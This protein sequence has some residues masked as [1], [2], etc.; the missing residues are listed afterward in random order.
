MQ[1]YPTMGTNVFFPGDSAVPSVSQLYKREYRHWWISFTMSL[2]PPATS[3]LG[4][5]VGYP[6]LDNALF[7][8][9]P[10]SSL[11]HKKF[12]QP[13]FFYRRLY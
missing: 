6:T 13:N 12:L 8:P 4:I 5:P 2:D 11:S 10:H 3:A 9:P 1:L 7:R